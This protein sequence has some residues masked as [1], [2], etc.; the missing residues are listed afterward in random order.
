MRY[1]YRWKSDCSF[2]QWGTLPLISHPWHEGFLSSLSCIYTIVLQNR[3]KSISPSLLG[4]QHQCLLTARPSAPMHTTKVHP[5]SSRGNRWVEVETRSKH[6]VLP[7]SMIPVATPP[8]PIGGQY[9]SALAG[10][11]ES[12]FCICMKVNM[13]KPD[14]L[15]GHPESVQQGDIVESHIV[16][17]KVTC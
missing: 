11:A 15:A 2:N 13:F 9:S 17:Y 6:C 8:S 16:C 7:L 10:P 5:L 1:S 4:A 12:G 3:Q 14:S